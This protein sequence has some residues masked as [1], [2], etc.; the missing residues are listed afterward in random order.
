MKI[1]NIL[2]GALVVASLNAVAQ[3]DKP[4]P[5]S[6][7][8]DSTKTTKKPVKQKGKSK[9]DSLKPRPISPS[10]CPPCGMG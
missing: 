1:S 5:R 8:A 3:Q 9:P 10:Y 4:R 2:I 6:E 7:K